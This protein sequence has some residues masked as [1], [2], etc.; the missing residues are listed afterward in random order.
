MVGRVAARRWSL[1]VVVVA[2]VAFA[3]AAGEASASVT[4]GSDLTAAT[5]HGG[6]C[7]NGDP[8][9]WANS[10]LPGH[11]ITA[12]FSGVVVRWRVKGSAMPGHTSVIFRII[13]PVGGGLFV[14]AGSA[15]AT[16]GTTAATYTNSVDLP[17]QA[18]D[19]IGLDGDLSNL[20][21]V[22]PNSNGNAQTVQWSP[23]LADGGA[24]RKQ[25]TGHNAEE[26]LL[27]AD[28][29][30]PP[31]SS[32]TAAAC[33]GGSGATITVTA[34]PD[35]ATGP[36]AAHYRVD[37]GPEQ[38]TATTGNPGVAKVPVPPGVHSLE[39]WGEDQLSQQE[40]PHHTLTVGC[41]VPVPQATIATLGSLSETHNTFAAAKGSTPLTGQTARSHPR[42]TTFSFTLDQPA[43]VKIAIQTKTKGR[44]VNG[45]CKPDSRRLRHKPRCTRTLT[46]ATLTRTGHAGL[47]R[48]PFS[49]RIRG[50]ALIPGRYQAVFTA[51]D[52]AGTSRRRSLKFTIVTR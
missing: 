23:P 18:G 51:T 14:G 8:C 50:K 13:R 35:P 9:T 19:S 33:P 52:I 3:G 49:G 17:V 36:K 1:V 30:A 37:G 11:T 44:L 48:V 39:Y 22:T 40:T 41:P 31:T 26:L 38:V 32:A 47:N 20:L 28:I 4:I 2:S 12:P 29:V 7:L 16:I 45:R 10:D 24:A 15:P 25:D 27:N 21:V 46:T 34:D 42:G 43:T 5:E 6:D